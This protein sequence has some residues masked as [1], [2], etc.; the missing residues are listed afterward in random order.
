VI[1]IFPSLGWQEMF[2]LLVIGLLLY[3]RNLPDAGRSLGRVMAQ[4]KRSFHDFKDQLDRDGQISDVKKAFKETAEEM[5][6]VAKV[7][8]ALSNPK[9]ALRD[10]T[11]EAMSSPLDDTMDDSGTEP[12]A[13]S[14]EVEAPSVDDSGSAHPDSLGRPGSDHNDSS[15]PSTGSSK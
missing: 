11:H 5:K 6:N 15:T 4:L 9:D 10:L 1:A 13:D 3:G 14:S 8:R 12:D 7:P 2:L